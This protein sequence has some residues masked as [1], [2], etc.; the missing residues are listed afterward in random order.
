VPC[1]PSVGCSRKRVR[2][3]SRIERKRSYEVQLYAYQGRFSSAWVRGDSIERGSFLVFGLVL[4]APSVGL[5]CDRYRHAGHC[6][7]NELGV[8]S[9]ARRYA[10]DHD[11]AVRIDTSPCN[12]WRQSNAGCAYVRTLFG[13]YRHQWAR[14]SGS[15][16]LVSSQYLCIKPARNTLHVREAGS[17]LDPWSSLG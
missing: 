14:V 11:H 12:A 16:G 15:A 6:S 13:W 17:G 2:H 10:A 1:Y 4:C 9:H 8:D 3:E 5:G 7:S